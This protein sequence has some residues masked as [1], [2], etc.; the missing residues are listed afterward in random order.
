MKR[1]IKQSKE[2]KCDECGKEVDYEDVAYL[3]NESTHCSPFEELECYC[4]DCY[5][6][7]NT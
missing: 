4:K 5:E 1:V 3:G 2:Y 7:S 6:K